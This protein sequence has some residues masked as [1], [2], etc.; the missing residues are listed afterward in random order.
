MFFSTS[1]YV[2]TCKIGTRCT[3]Q[4]TVKYLE[5]FKEDL[6]WFKVHPQFRHVFHMPEE[7]N[8]MTQGLWML[9][10]R[11]AQ[12]EMDREC[13]FVVNGV[14]IRYSIKEHALLCGF[15]CHDYSEE[16]QPS[17]KIV[18]ADLKF[19]KKIF[20]KV[21]EIKIVDVEKKL[22]EMKKCGEKK[23]TDRK[24]LA[25]LLFLCKVIA[26]K[27]KVDGNIDKFFLK[28]VDDVRAC[29]TFPWGRF[30]FDG[31]ME[32]IKSVMKSLKGKA[33]LQTC[34]SG[35]ILPLEVTI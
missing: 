19:A 14:P 13:W 32:G 10:L 35:F 28:I 6:P 25:I 11:T 16:L 18:D 20:K 2:K 5:E 24:K 9:L 21:S 15:D 27:S 26:V 34:F 33:K 3:V 7:K 1:E 22:D 4:Q 17:M 8:H 12:T 23:K 31:C 29:E 30:T